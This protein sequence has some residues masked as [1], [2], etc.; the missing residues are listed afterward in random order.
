MLRT[1]L[2]VELRFTGGEEHDLQSALLSFH[3]RWAVNL[4]LVAVAA[5]VLHLQQTLS[6]QLDAIVLVPAL[7]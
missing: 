1:Q 3:Q 5:S 6:A 7:G 4:L 2:R